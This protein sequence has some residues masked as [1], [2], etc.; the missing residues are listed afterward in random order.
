MAFQVGNTNQY[1]TLELDGNNS[2]EQASELHRQLLAA[3]AQS[4]AVNV[5]AQNS[6]AIDI[7]IIQILAA[8]QTCCSELRIEHPSKEF[9]CSLDGCGMRRH[10][11]AALRAEK[12][13]GGAQ[14]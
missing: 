1:V 6:G 3:G 11:R 2:V 14:A 7:T 9:L 13:E 5:M 8:L 4:K 10:V 12:L